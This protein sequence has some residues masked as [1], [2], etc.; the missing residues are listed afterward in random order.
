MLVRPSVHLSFLCLRKFLDVAISLYA[1]ELTRIKCG[2]E[3]REGREGRREGGE[4]R[5]GRREGGRERGDVQDED[6]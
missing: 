3:G 6:V 1:A 5:E 2:R 4:G